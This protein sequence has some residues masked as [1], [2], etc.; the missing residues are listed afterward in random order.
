MTRISRFTLNKDMLEKLFTLFFEV[1]GRR[2]N[3]DEFQKVIFDILSPV[4]RIM[5]A[6]RIA[7]SYLLLKKIDYKIICDT[8]KVSPTTVAKFKL[9]LER[10]EGM[11]PVF[12][13]MLTNEKIELFL[14]E[15]FSE[16]FYPGKP[17]INWK[18][19]WEL[20]R[21]IQEKKETGL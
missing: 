21:S 19:A 8:L 10:S 11:V 5:I 1:V 3:R 20:K 2:G 14:G 18:S 16:I 6:K 4:E 17:G 12:G 15:L 13:R 9:L 7:V